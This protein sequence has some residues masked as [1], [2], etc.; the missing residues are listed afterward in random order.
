MIHILIADADP[1]MN[2][3]LSLWLQ[4]Q[5]LPVTITEVQNVQSLIRALALELPDILLLDWDLY[6]SPA[7]ETCR[8]L[9]KAYP[10]LKV[11]L[12]SAKAGDH[13]A[14]EA[15]GADFVYKGTPP[16]ELVTRLHSVFMEH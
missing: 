7:P 9:R 16:D 2:K 11:V 12:L 6:G 1:A 5:I 14:A 15:A 3:A 10:H 4:R 13:T 8:L